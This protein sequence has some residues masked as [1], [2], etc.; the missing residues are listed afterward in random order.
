MVTVAP[1]WRLACLTQPAETPG[2]CFPPL[3][4]RARPPD[5]QPGLR[6]PC[7]KPLSHHLP[8]PWGAEDRFSAL[9][10]AGVGCMCHPARSQHAGIGAGTSGTCS[11]EGDFG[12]L[13]PPQSPCSVEAEEASLSVS[14]LHQITNS[15]CAGGAGP[16]RHPFATGTSLSPVAQQ[17][18]GET[19]VTAVLISQS[20]CFH[21]VS[22]WAWEPDPPAQSSASSLSHTWAGVDARFLPGW[23][24]EWPRWCQ[25]RAQWWRLSPGQRAGVAQ[26]AR[27]ARPFSWP[28]AGGK[29]W[30][31]TW[32]RR[33]LRPR[34]CHHQAL[35]E[36]TRLCKL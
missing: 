12:V 17:P 1:R 19:R 23:Q 34:L 6:L 8:G 2:L 35:A 27:L 9:L 10:P 22:L 32:D 28:T 31:P 5:T 24:F 11:E 21:C 14:S 18:P 4:S 3:V 15:S 16:Q 13:W 26:T 25:V 33:V 30:F 29:R 7:R 20:P 36:V